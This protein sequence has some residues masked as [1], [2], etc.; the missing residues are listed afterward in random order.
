VESTQVAPGGTAVWRI[1]VTNTGN[2]PLTEFA[3]ADPAFPGCQTAGAAAAPA[4][5]DPG[6]SFSF[7]CADTNVTASHT[8]VVVVEGIDPGGT[9]IDDDDDARVELGTPPVIIRPPPGGFLA[10]AGS[11]LDELMAKAALA[12]TLGLLAVGATA[13]R[14]GDRR[15]AFAEWVGA[16]TAE[17]LLGFARQIS[18]K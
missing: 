17:E 7:T 10:L 12:L 18:R 6:Q 2:V 9:P 1:T 13:R 8:N 15:A 11:N 14:R 3:I 16:A 5:L 4:R